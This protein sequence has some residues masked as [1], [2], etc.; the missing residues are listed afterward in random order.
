MRRFW[1]SG[2]LSLVNFTTE[3]TEENQEVSRGYTGM[4][5]IENSAFL[6][7]KIRV[8][9]RLLLVLLWVLCG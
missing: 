4:E 6:F 8:H 2:R 3:D 1:K 7:T 5:R 9:L